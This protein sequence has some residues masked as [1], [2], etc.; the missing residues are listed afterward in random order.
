MEMGLGESQLFPNFEHYEHSVS[1]IK[2]HFLTRLVDINKKIASER[3][4]PHSLGKYF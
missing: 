4:V 2:S 3:P 1:A